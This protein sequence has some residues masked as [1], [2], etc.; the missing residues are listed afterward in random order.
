MEREK[1]K[2]NSSNKRR[3]KFIYKKRE[4][5]NTKRRNV[6]ERPKEEGNITQLGRKEEK[7]Y[8]K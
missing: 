2:I 4:K 8:D 3:N 7:E 1:K 5:Q 6:Y